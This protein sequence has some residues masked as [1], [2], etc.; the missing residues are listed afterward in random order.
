[1]MIKLSRDGDPY[2]IEEVAEAFCI[3]IEIVEEYVARNMDRVGDDTVLISKGRDLP[4]LRDRYY[5][6][7]REALYTHPNYLPH[8]PFG[9][10][11]HLSDAE[12]TGAGRGEFEHSPRS[13]RNSMRA[14]KVKRT[15]TGFVEEEWR[16]S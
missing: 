14:C 4:N 7:N 8:I 16:I 5:A 11:E 6:N 9:D 13:V 12:N 2:T 10:L 15:G 1:M 3:P